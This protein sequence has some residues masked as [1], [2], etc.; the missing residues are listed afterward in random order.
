VTQS[1]DLDPEARALVDRA[2]VLLSSAGQSVE[3]HEIER[4]ALGA[5]AAAMVTRREHRARQ[6][7]GVKVIASLDLD[8]DASSSSSTD[9]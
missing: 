4:L 3:E 5:V 8:P 7:E 6:L 1:S 9:T 2:Y